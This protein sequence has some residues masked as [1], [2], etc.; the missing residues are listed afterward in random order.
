[1]LEWLKTWFDWRIGRVD[2]GVGGDGVWGLE[3]GTVRLCVQ[4]GMQVRCSADEQVS[5]GLE[6]RRG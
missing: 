6:K 5:C 1:V 2:G 3:G 4:V